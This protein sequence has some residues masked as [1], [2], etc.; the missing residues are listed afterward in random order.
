MTINLPL[1]DTK[2][3]GR[4]AISINLLKSTWHNGLM[5]EKDVPAGIK[6]WVSE[7]HTGTGVRTTTT[8]TFAST[9]E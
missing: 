6:R 4:I 1:T 2:E 9:S 5:Y 7:S 3:Y 8:R